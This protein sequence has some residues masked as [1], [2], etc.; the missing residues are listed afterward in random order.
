MQEELYTSRIFHAKYYMHGKYFRK[1]SYA[2]RKNHAKYHMQVEYFMQNMCY[3][4]SCTSISYS[5]YSGDV[6]H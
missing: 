4:I 2:G 3:A 6:K 1:L 5:T